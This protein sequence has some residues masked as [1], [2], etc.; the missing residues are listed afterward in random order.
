MD[1]MKAIEAEKARR[2]S[3]GKEYASGGVFVFLNSEYQG[4]MNELRDPHK[5]VPGCIAVDESGRMWESI[6]GN[7]QDGAEIWYEIEPDYKAAL[8]KRGGWRP[9][10][11][12][13][14]MKPSFKKQKK[15]F[16]LSPESVRALADLQSILGLPS[17]SAVVEFI[18]LKA[19]REYGKSAGAQ[20]VVEHHLDLF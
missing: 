10:S 20:K 6:G 8:E 5:W 13:K 17:Q 2:K 1:Y 11:G 7:D 16:S 3:D 18:A 4:W 14:K 12:R 9:G 15:A 19:V